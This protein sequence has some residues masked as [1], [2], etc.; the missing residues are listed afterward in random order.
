MIAIGRFATRFSSPRPPCLRG[1]SSHPESRASGPPADIV[2][3]VERAPER[4]VG[5]GRHARGL[6][7]R[8]DLGLG[9]AEEGVEAVC[10]RPFVDCHVLAL[11][12]VPAMGDEP[13]TL[14]GVHD[15]TD[16]VALRRALLLEGRWIAADANGDDD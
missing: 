5:W 16:R 2:A 8:A 3:E 6:H 10:V 7:E 14:G 4:D 11:R 13:V 1:C 9:F 12:A 15:A